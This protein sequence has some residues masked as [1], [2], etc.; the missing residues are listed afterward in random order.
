MSR[1]TDEELDSIPCTYG[2]PDPRAI[3]D[4]QHKKDMEWVKGQLDEF[5]VVSP[6]QL[7]EIATVDDDGWMAKI[8]IASIALAKKVESELSEALS[9]SKGEER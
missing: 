9:L 7:G 5:L 1:L 2:Y 3:A 8:V 4:A 6:E